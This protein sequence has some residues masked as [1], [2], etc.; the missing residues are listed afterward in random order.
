MVWI[1]LGLVTAFFGVLELG[2]PNIMS[3][4]QEDL[5]FGLIMM[6]II[7]PVASVGLLM[8]GKYALAGEY[9]DEIIPSLSPIENLVVSD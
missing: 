7:T 4:K 9:D 2:L 6:L 1:L 5:I 8:F 3:G